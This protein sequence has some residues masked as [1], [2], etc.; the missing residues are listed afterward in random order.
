MYKKISKILICA[1][2]LV[3]AIGAVSAMENNTDD[4][5]ASESSDDVIAASEENAD[6]I[7]SQEQQDN[8]VA[9]SADKAAPATKEKNVVT[10]SASKEKTNVA[11]KNSADST[12]KVSKLSATKNSQ[13]STKIQKKLFTLA[14]MVFPYKY[15]KTDYKNLPTKMKKLYISKLLVFNKKF[16]N[17]LK[18]LKAKG[19]RTNTQ[20][21]AKVYKRGTN[22]LIVY[23]LYCY[24]YV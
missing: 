21:F 13:K 19:W 9:A 10:V 2:I 5:I 23:R 7:T 4:A 11:K 17:T 3:L 22:A 8:V 16:S 15:I 12:K 24:R 6:V 1:L 18:V 14:S 20:P